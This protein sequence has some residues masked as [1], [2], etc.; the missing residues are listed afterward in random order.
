MQL[1]VYGGESV[2]GNLKPYVLQTGQGLNSDSA[3][4]ASTASTG[5]QFT[6]I[7]SHTDGGAP[8]HIHSRED[9]YFY[10]VEGTITVTCGDQVF[11]VGPRGFVFLPRN[12]PHAWDVIGERATVLMMTVPAGLDAFLAEHHA[13]SSASNAVKDQIAARYGITWV[14]D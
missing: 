12:I 13:A 3:L 7:E 6:L 10:V 8:M 2:N 14:R 1:I 5:G 9:E 11:E 4:K